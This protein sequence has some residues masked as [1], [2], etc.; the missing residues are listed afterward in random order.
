MKPKLHLLTGSMEE[1]VRRLEQI[2]VIVI[3]CWALSAAAAVLYVAPW[4]A[5]AQATQ[6]TQ[7]LRVSELVVVDPKGVE[8]VRIGGDLPD[9]V[10][11]GKRVP[12]GE[13]AA[14]VMLYDGSGQERGGYV[15]FEPSSN[16][17][18]TLDT[19]KRQTALFAAGP[20]SGSALVMWS[21][22]NNIDMRSDEDGARITLT[23]DG[24]LIQQQ[25]EIDRISDAGCKDYKD[26]IIRSG[27]DRASKACRSR[28]G[29]KACRACLDNK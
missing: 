25:P 24:Q 13:K 20:D 17:A 19:K 21:G 28:F 3:A 16:I 18:L 4:K 5:S 12:R 26:I 9:A 2:L 23:K 6:G 29:E 11:N 22:Q 14:G 1:R 8:R 10:I 27:K 7:S 15:T